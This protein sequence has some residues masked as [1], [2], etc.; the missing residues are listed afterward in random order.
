MDCLPNYLFIVKDKSTLPPTTPPNY[1]IHPD[2]W[3]R[4][5]NKY[6]VP[7][8]SGCQMSMAEQCSNDWSTD[9]D[10]YYINNS[11]SNDESVNVR[12]NRGAPVFIMTDVAAAVSQSSEAR[13]IGN[14]MLLNAAALRFFTNLSS[15][16]YTELQN[17]L[18]TESPLVT[19]YITSP[20]EVQRPILRKDTAHSSIIDNDPI[21]TRLL[22]SID[23]NRPFLWLMYQHLLAN[24]PSDPQ[25]M[26]SKTMVYLELEFKNL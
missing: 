1:C 9:C 4:T 20:G 19:Y 15:S 7:Q 14:S 25:I 26:Q 16:T 12:S 10:T 23:L 5:S 13:S 22:L 11:G 17:P 21:M 8:S 6:D 2:V 24:S 18:D 3:G